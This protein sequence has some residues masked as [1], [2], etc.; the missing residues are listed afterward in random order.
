MSGAPVLVGQGAKRAS[1]GL[2]RWNPLQP[3]SEESLA[4]GG[5]VY[6]C[7]AKSLKERLSGYGAR[8]ITRYEI[9]DLVLQY[10]F[11]K[12]SEA[13]CYKLLGV[14]RSEYV[15]RYQAE[16]KMPPYVPRQID[17]ALRNALGQKNFVLLLGPSKA[18]KTR[19]AYEALLEVAPSTPMVVPS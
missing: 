1:I 18:G 17:D 10:P 4:V 15:D 6:A 8:W 3:N 2:V 13:D 9:A 12:V 19:T 14:W 16:S 5:T 11:P 7:P